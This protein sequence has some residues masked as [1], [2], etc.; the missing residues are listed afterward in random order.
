MAAEWFSP[1][2]IATF[3]LAGVAVWSILETRKIHKKELHIREA[4]RKLSFRL[5]VLDEARDWTRE[6]VK[7]GFLYHRPPVQRELELREMANMFDDVARHVDI[8]RMAGEVF[9]SEL[10]DPVENAITLLKKYQESPGEFAD[11]AYFDSL[12]AL[13][14]I[15][16]KLRKT[17]HF[18]SKT[19]TL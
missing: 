2:A 14:T 7:L 12:N 6:C 8:V 1:L 17:L 9:E 3:I 5:R 18:E 11:K 19:I 15:I 16:N 13:L 4:D 10:K